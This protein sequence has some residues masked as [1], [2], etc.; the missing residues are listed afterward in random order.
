METDLKQAAENFER[1]FNLS[2]LRMGIIRRRDGMIMA[3]NDR[4]IRDVGYTREEA[5]GHS[6]FEFDQ[7]LS[8]DLRL[9]I[10]ELLKEGKPLRDL[11]GRIWTK[12]GEERLIVTSAEAVEFENEPCFLWAT[13]DITE[14]ARAEDAWRRNEELFRAIVQ[15]Q[16]EMIVRWKPDGTRTFVN[17]AYARVFGGEPEDHIGT[18][19]LP[20]VAERYRDQVWEKIDSLTPENPLATTIHESISAGNS[21]WQEWTDRGIFNEQ[22]RLV[23]LQST[24]RDITERIQ[25]EEQNRRLIHDLGERVKELTLL[26]ETARLIQNEEKSVLDLLREVVALIPSAWQYPECTAA[27]VSF[28]DIEFKTPNFA[29]TQWSQSADLQAAETTGVIEVYYLEQ[30]P[31]ADVGPFLFEERKLID[32]MAE[33]LSTALARR[34]VQAALRISEETFA[35]AFRASPEPISIY[36]HRDGRLQDVNERWTAVYGYARSEAIGRTSR[37]L[38]LVDQKVRAELR[39]ALDQHGYVREVEIE[40]RTRQGQIRN[41]SLAAEQITINNELCDI[42]L[43]YDITERKRAESELRASREQLRALSRRMQSAREEEGARIAREIHDV[44]GASLTGLKWDLEAISKSLSKT[45]N[46]EPFETV[47]NRIPLMSKQIDSTIDVVRRISSELRPSVLDD[48]GL[49]AAIEW[50][51]QQFQQRTGIVCQCE[52]TFDP[53]D[54]SRERATAVFRIFQEVLTNVLR[55]SQA[56]LVVVEMSANDDVFSLRVDDNGRGITEAEV[57]NRASLGLLGMRE[58]ARLIGGEVSVT[59]SNG[60]GTTVIVRLPLH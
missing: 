11:A 51:S 60:K 42:F 48:L 4:W 12:A 41:I 43:Q 26:H 33:M 17:R 52:S 25:A 15:D 45:G 57:N 30:R 22:G 31:D 56:T 35:K 49:A 27:R 38:N 8:P 1:I 58:R 59:G 39:A 40:I 44:L 18:S 32:S 10:S 37:E 9:R 50:Q 53:Q 55:H 2:P 5:V 28:G 34:F 19:F 14:R 36:R 54:L 13:D 16:T 29:R 6:I 23:E 24:G 46:G 20:L 21:T 7:R 47:R 3:V